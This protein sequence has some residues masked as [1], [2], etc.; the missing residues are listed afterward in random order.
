MIPRV[1]RHWPA[2]AATFSVNVHPGLTTSHGPQAYV[3]PAR[4]AEVAWLIHILG[5][6]GRFALTPWR[7]AFIMGRLGARDESQRRD[8][9]LCGGGT[10]AGAETEERRPRLVALDDPPRP[11]AP[12]LRPEAAGRP[13]DGL[14]GCGNGGLLEVGRRNGRRGPVTGMAVGPCGCLPSDP[15][16]VR[17][18]RRLF[19]GAWRSTGAS[20]RRS[21]TIQGWRARS[22]S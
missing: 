18:P 10:G 13:G 21:W 12:V 11:R 1:A 9:S 2:P 17:V 5:P 22:T 4:T 6:R 15:L 20:T 7:P 19:H 8:Q 16:R 14:L 3:R